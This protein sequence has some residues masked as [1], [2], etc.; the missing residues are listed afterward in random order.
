M[1]VGAKRDS[2][3]TSKTEIGQLQVTLA[4]NEQVLRL[5]I[6]VEDTV[7]VAVADTLAQLAHE[8]LDDCVAKTQAVEIGT[9]TLGKGLAATTVS[10]GE[11][12]HVL[13]QVAVEELEDEVQLVTV[14][15]DNVEQAHNVG[16]AHLL[17]EGNL[18]DG[19][20]GNALIL[21]FKTDLLECDDSATV[22]KVARLVDDTVGTCI[23]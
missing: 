15:M 6:T 3:G 17:E 16:I 20:R 11:R 13:L 7:T 2:E 21:G 4:I 10:D 12:L 5:Q 9:S 8:L 22:G 19:G 1:G 23:G 14:G 18:A